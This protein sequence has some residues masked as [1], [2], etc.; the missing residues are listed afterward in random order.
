MGDH[1]K[2]PVTTA[3]QIKNNDNTITHTDP[4]AAAAAADEQYEQMHTTTPIHQDNKNTSMD[5]ATRE[6]LTVS[7]FYISF[8][9]LFYCTLN[10]I[11]CIEIV[12][13]VSSIQLVTSH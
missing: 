8:L 3:R 1:S 10:T 5:T 7:L 13:V 2:R 6:K 9:F 11:V 4:T 12:L